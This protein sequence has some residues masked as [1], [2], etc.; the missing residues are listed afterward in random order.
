MYDQVGFGLSSQFPEQL[1]NASFWTIDPFVEQLQ[2]LVSYLGVDR[3]HDYMGHSFGTAYGI[4]YAA[5]KDIRQG[6]RKLI[7][8]SPSAS[9]SLANDSVWRSREALPE[10]LRNTLKKHEAEGTTDDDE[11]QKAAIASMHYDFCRLDIWP[12]ELLKSMS[13]SSASAFVTL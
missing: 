5:N 13:Y 10:G 1:G 12:D 11:Y 2:Q 8:W 4:N 3:E 7:L 6:L 9:A